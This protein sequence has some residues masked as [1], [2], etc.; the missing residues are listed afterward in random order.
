MPAPSAERAPTSCQCR[1]NNLKGVISA[2]SFSTWVHYLRKA[3]PGSSRLGPFSC[4]YSAECV[5]GEFSEVHYRG[6]SCVWGREREAPER[7]DL[8][9]PGP[10]RSH[11]R[12]H[13]DGCIREGEL[14]CW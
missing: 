7:K 13:A 3:G 6:V 4:P 8:K 9:G 2:S 10:K 5:E 14:A 11:E 1:R 12:P